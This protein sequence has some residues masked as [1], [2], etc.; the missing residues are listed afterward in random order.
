MSTKRRR[1]LPHQRSHHRPS[2]ADYLPGSV[3]AGRSPLRRSRGDAWFLLVNEQRSEVCSRAS[4]LLRE[5]VPT[6]M[7]GADLVRD[8][9][10][11]RRDSRMSV[12]P[13]QAPCRSAPCARIAGRARS[14]RLAPNSPSMPGSP[15]SRLRERA[16][17]RVLFYAPRSNLNLGTEH[18]PVPGTHERR[19]G[20]RPRLAPL[21]TRPIEDKVRSRMSEHGFS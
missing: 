3:E 2:N 10:R 7:A 8:G 15:L 5:A 19:S 6:R 17:E 16:G 21:R 12:A 13:H 20:L 14:Y 11:L 9:R 4:S 18:S 1:R